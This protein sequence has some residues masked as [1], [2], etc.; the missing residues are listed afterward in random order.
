MQKMVMI[1][2]VYPAECE[3]HYIA[4]DLLAKNNDYL[5]AV[6]QIELRH[7]IFGLNSKFVDR[8]S[9]FYSLGQRPEPEV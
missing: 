9:I 6:F 8:L 3:A 4:E 2:P 5:E 7:T 1:V